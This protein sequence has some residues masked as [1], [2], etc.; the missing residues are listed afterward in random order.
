MQGE[1]LSLLI[2]VLGG[3]LLQSPVN[4]LLKDGGIQLPIKLKMMISSLLNKLTIIY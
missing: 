4:Q 1:P 2:Y 3:D